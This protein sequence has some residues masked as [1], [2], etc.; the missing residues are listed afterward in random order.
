MSEQAIIDNTTRMSSVDT[1]VADLRTLGI[2]PGATLLV[3]ASLSSI[4]WVCGG[5]VAVI[6]ALEQVLTPQGTLVMPTHSGDLSDPAEW[7]HPPVPQAWWE[8]IRQT[9]PAFN[10][11]LTPV[12]AVGCIPETFRKQREVLRS[13]HPQVSFAAWGKHAGYITDRH[14]LE[15]NLGESSPLARLFDLDSQVLLLGVGHANNTSLHL[16]E[17][18]ANF[19]G[20]KTVTLGAPVLVDGV[21]QW[22]QYE[23]IFLYD[24]DFEQIG[25]DFARE[26]G[27][28][29]HGK[30]GQADTLLIPQRPLVDFAVK[31]MERNRL[32]E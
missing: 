15:F 28:Q 22:I 11:D 18:R 29:I 12:R 26:T 16:A 10:P 19:P 21:R 4:G 14:S 8:S 32:N 30:V 2:H 9:M 5:A 31:W 3:H 25:A 27:K 13:N 7:Q 1:L 23:D 17:Y 6:Q 24:E 20:K